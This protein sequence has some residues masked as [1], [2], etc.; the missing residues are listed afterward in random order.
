MKQEEEEEER[1]DFPQ[2]Q[3]LISRGRKEYPS[4]E[5]REFS[6]CDNTFQ[7]EGIKLSVMG[8]HFANSHW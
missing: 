2:R 4:N 7:V 3:F 5:T 6:L 8:C 1:E